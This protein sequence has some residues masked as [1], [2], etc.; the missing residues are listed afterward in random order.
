GSNRNGVTQADW[1]LSTGDAH[2]VIA[3]LAENL[4]AFTGEVAK[5][6]E[7]GARGADQ[8][9][10]ASGA[11]EFHQTVPQLKAAVHVASH[12]SMVNQRLRNTVHR[13]TRNLGEF[14]QLGQGSGTI[15]QCVENGCCLVQYAYAAAC[16]HSSSIT[17]QYLRFKSAYWKSRSMKCQ[18]WSIK[19]S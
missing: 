18:S 13:R 16:C 5:L 1:T 12:Q 2:T 9:V 11:G 7:H 14:H 4:R 19:C 15:L 3:L 6:D 10:F 17:S 8:S